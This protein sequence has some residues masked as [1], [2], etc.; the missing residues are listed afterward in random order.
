MAAFLTKGLTCDS[1]NRHY[2]I[3]VFSRNA[4]MFV[5][6]GSHHRDLSWRQGTLS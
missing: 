6:N 2:Q 3:L 1:I 4:S 5:D